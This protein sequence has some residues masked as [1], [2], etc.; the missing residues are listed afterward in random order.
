MAQSCQFGL[1]GWARDRG[2]LGL[3]RLPIEQDGDEIDSLNRNRGFKWRKIDIPVKTPPW[4]QAW[5]N[6]L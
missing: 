6:E 5:V 2:V 4:G 1:A 3:S